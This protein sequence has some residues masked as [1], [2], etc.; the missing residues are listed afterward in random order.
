MSFEDLHRPLSAAGFR[1][2]IRWIILITG[3]LLMLQQLYGGWLVSNLGLTPVLVWQNHWWWQP[4]T[5]QFLH[6]GLFHWLFNM[7]ILWMFGRELEIRWGTVNFL[8]YFFITGL[9]AAFCVLLISPNSGVPTIGSSG[10]VFG[11][12]TAFAMVFPQATM[13]LYFVVPV[14]AWQ[15]AA[16]FAFIELFAGLEGGGSGVA[17]FAH[18]GGMLTGY[19]Y[20]RFWGY[21]SLGFPNPWP[22]IKRYLQRLPPFRKKPPVQFH[23]LTD[24]LAQ[25]VDRILDKILK[26]GVDSLTPEEKRLM[27]RYS[28]MKK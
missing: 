13:Y 26:Q 22:S 3:V 6:G 27:D 11:L 16:L 19:L 2:A 24:D 12:L 18:L 1:G 28:R 10:A 8:K 23:E 7:F 5:Y 14:K 25:Q 9:G 20:L 21:L 15:A 4:F 17:R